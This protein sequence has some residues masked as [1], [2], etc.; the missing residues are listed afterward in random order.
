MITVLELGPEH[1]RQTHRQEY[2]DKC[3]QDKADHRA[4]TCT[5]QTQCNAGER[6]VG[7]SKISKGT[8][9]NDHPIVCLL[10][11]TSARREEE[12]ELADSSTQLQTL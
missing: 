2:T 7:A 10:A 3:Y 1:R 4:T 5:M 12:K 9:S 8:C 6:L 11:M